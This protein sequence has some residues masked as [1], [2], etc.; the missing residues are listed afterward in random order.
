MTS[1]C[2]KSQSGHRQVWSLKTGWRIDANVLNPS[3]HSIST[4]GSLLCSP[5]TKGHLETNMKC[6]MNLPVRPSSVF[7]I[8]YRGTKKPISPELRLFQ[9]HAQ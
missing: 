7:E 4:T 1:I 6:A 5:H 3:S 2:L 8:S 9:V